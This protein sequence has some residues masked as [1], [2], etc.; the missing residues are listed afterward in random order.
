[1]SIADEFTRLGELHESGALTEDEWTAAK[2][3]VPAAASAA[4]AAPDA[5]RQRE[6]R[7][8]Q[9]QNE[10]IQLDQEWE[11]ERQTLMT[12]GRYGSRFVPTVNGSIFGGIIVGVIGLLMLVFG[13]SVPH[14]GSFTLFGIAGI[15]VGIAY[16]VSGTAKANAYRQAQGRY[17]QRREELTAQVRDMEKPRRI[18]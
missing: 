1:M 10:V 4:P 8:L 3:K 15:L 17:Q 5:G 14:T 16:G 2:A 11:R 6:A 18:L 7:R 9:I 13:N 12:H